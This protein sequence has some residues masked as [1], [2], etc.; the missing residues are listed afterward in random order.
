MAPFART[1]VPLGFV[2][3]D[4]ELDFVYLRWKGGSITCKGRYGRRDEVTPLRVTVSGFEG[5]ASGEIGVARHVDVWIE[6]GLLHDYV[7]ELSRDKM[8]KDTL[9]FK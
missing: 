2:R 8:A 1:R 9:D 3:L 5:V 6:V 7:C 4:E